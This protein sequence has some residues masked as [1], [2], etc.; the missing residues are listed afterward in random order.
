MGMYEKE[1][2]C[3]AHRV[4]FKMEKENKNKTNKGVLLFAKSI[5]SYVEAL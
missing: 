3:I 1:I 4:Q 5:E 2:E